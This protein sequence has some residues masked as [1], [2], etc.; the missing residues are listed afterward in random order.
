[1][2]LKS[3]TCVLFLCRISKNLRTIISRQ[4]WL[5]N[6]WN[7]KLLF[8]RPPD[9]RGLFVF[10]SGRVCVYVRSLEEPHVLRN[11]PAHQKELKYEVLLILNSS[12]GTGTAKEAFWFFGHESLLLLW[13]LGINSWSTRRRSNTTNSQTTFVFADHQLLAGLEWL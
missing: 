1:M 13:D 10:I 7:P 9:S 5:M 6:V 4:K 3:F 2:L 12:V 11:D 8:G